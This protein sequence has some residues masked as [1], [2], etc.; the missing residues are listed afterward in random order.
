MAQPN[1]V[2][3]SNRPTER[4]TTLN[5]EPVIVWEVDIEG[6]SFSARGGGVASGQNVT[7]LKQGLRVASGRLDSEAAAQ[8]PPIP[9]FLGSWR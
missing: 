3:S 9:C 4:P 7:L 1:I 2:A 6:I 5:G 8:S